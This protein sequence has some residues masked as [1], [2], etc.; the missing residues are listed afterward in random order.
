[1]GAQFPLYFAALAAAIGLAS[2]FNGSM[3]MRFGMHELTHKALWVL[4]ISSCVFVVVAW[5]TA[6]HPALWQ[7]MVACF[8]MFLCIGVM[9]GNL[10][11]IAMEPLGHVAGTAASVIGSISNLVGVFLGLLIGRAFDGTVTPMAIGF[12]ALSV[13]SL[14][15]TSTLKPR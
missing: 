3:V 2:I 1:V 5:I 15:L 8:V 6:G 10:N 12:A 4:T 13:V 11:A 9:F 7:L 14:V